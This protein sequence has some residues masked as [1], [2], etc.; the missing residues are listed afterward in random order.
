[1]KIKKLSESIDVN[2]IAHYIIDNYEF[3]DMQDKHDCI[4]SIRDS[5][6]NEKTI[7]KEELEQFIGAH[8]GRDK[9]NESKSIV[10]ETALEGTIK[11]IDDFYYDNVQNIRDADWDEV[12]E[13]FEEN[14]WIS[15]DDMVIPKG[16]RLR[17]VDHNLYYNF[18]K[19]VDNSNSE[20]IPILIEQ[21]ND[22]P[23]IAFENEEQ[24]KTQKKKNKLKCPDCG[25]VSKRQECEHEDED[26]DSYLTCPVCDTVLH[27]S[28]SIK[29]TLDESLFEASYGGAFDVADDQYFTRE[30]I[31]T[32]CETVLE[33]INETFN[34]KYVLGGTWFENGKWIVNVQT[35]NGMEEYEAQI[36]VDINKIKSARDLKEYVAG[37]MA[38]ALISQIKEFSEDLNES[39]DTSIKVGD[40]VHVDVAKK[41]GIVKKVNGEYIDVETDDGENPIRIDTYYKNEV[42]KLD[43]AVELLS[44]D[45]T[46]DAEPIKTGSAV[47]MAQIISDLIKDE[48]EAID[49]YNSAIATAESEGYSNMIEV[50]TDIQ[51]EENVHIGQ[52]QEL[53]KMVDP[54]ASKIEDGE[55]EAKQ[56][57]SDTSVEEI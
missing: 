56:E 26:G 18:Y 16:T 49:G 53:M 10:E 17:K 6:K 27:E 31:E 9:V 38:A 22:I 12:I 37:D 45:M 52:L 29:Q 32:A 44:E 24:P 34:D 21:E 50:L 20:N 48:Y 42:K 8:N 30:D 5:F 55:H 14:G 54:N 3:D 23:Y 51:A 41:D 25:T 1:M 40:K 46:T 2:N 28:K 19:V 13:L 4:N 7:S 36:D 47:G 35:E 57:I 39:I 15:G 11:L 43:E 33:H